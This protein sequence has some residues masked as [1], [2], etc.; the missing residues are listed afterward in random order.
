MTPPPGLAGTGGGAI[1]VPPLPAGAEAA[2]LVRSHA[3]G[4]RSPSLL[5]A[6]ASHGCWHS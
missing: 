3:T 2:R 5:Y 6:D 1:E 4:R